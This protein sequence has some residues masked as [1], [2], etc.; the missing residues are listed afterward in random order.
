M[1]IEARGPTFYGLYISDSI[2]ILWLFLFL[3]GNDVI[4]IKIQ[5]NKIKNNDTFKGKQRH[6]VIKAKPPP[7][8]S[9]CCRNLKSK[10]TMG[11]SK[12]RWWR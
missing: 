4:Y 7:T 11:G 9:C 10:K 12:I 6:N 5:W 1:F 2:G 8:F 3:Y